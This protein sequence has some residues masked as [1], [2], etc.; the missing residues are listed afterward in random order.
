MPLLFSTLTEADKQED[1]MRQVHIINVSMLL[2]TLEGSAFES[3][4]VLVQVL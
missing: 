3:S 2:S 1:F 4:D